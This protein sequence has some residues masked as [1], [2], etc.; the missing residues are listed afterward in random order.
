MASAFDFKMLLQGFRYVEA[1]SMRGFGLAR[2]RDVVKLTFNREMSCRFDVLR[3]DPFG[4]TPNQRDRDGRDPVAFHDSGEQS[5]GLGA[6]GSHRYEQG[7]VD[8]ILG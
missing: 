5:N 3:P 1:Q 8:L 6:E 7:Q 4:H 2:A